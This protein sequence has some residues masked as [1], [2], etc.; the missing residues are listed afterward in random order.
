MSSTKPRCKDCGANIKPHCNSCTYFKGDVN[1]KWV[2][3]VGAASHAQYLNSYSYRKNKYL[4][5]C[6]L[7]YNDNMFDEGSW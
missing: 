1:Q 3:E 4:K 2:V 7:S 6:L 5:G